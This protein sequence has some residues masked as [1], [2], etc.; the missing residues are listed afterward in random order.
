M[1]GLRLDRFAGMMDKERDVV[2]RSV[3]VLRRKRM[4]RGEESQAFCKDPEGSA[5][6]FV[7]LDLTNTTMS[8]VLHR[9]PRKE[10]GTYLLLAMVNS[11]A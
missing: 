1:N 6:D 8:S 3:T 11:Q 4:K 7:I 5:Y 9:I 10:T 2:E